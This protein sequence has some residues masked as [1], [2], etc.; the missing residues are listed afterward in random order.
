M[1]LLLHGYIKSTGTETASARVKKKKK[2]ITKHKHLIFISGKISDKQHSWVFMT[3]LPLVSP[4]TSHFL[5]SLSS[6]T[7][8]HD[9]LQHWVCLS[10]HMLL[11]QSSAQTRLTLPPTFCT[12]NIPTST[13]KSNTPNPAL[14]ATFHQSCSTSG[15]LPPVN[16]PNRET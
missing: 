11:A 4:S 12:L 1:S 15:G 14:P 9:A 2:P 16:S 7:D 10:L 5:R 3:A 13:S 6:F 8:L